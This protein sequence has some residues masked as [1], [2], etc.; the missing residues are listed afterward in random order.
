MNVASEA[1]VGMNISTVERET[2]LSKDVLRVWERRYGFPLPSRDAHGERHYPPEQVTKL[3]VIRRLMDSGMRPGRLI[4]LDVGALEQLSATVAAPPQETSVPLIV[5]ELVELLRSHDATALQQMLVQLLMR[6]GLQ[7]FVQETVAPLNRGIGEAWMRGKLQI[8]EEHLYTEQLQ[9][10]LRSAISA[11]PRRAAAPKVLLTTLPE[12][13]H[14]LGLLMVEALLASD[15]A[16]CVSLGTQT[17]VND[18]ALAATAHRAH[19]VALSFSAAFPT[20]VAGESLGALRRQLPSATQIWVGGE[21]S[22]RLRRVIAGVRIIAD[23]SLVLPALRDWRT[24][25]AGVYGT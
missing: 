5:E 3:R 16:H 21:M 14:S 25:Y 20:R 22:R 4:S 1:V 15:G 13:Q 6:Q 7:R 23:L 12:E 2:G 17:P 9:V 24:A 11:F 8:F 19:V 18:I 10:L